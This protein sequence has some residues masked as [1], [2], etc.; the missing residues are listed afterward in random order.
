MPATD[1]V[2]KAIDQITEIEAKIAPMQDKATRLK[3]FVNT[4]DELNGRPPR[5]EIGAL[6][7]LSAPAGPPQVKVWQPGDFYNRPLATAVRTI[8][9]ARFAVAGQKPSPATVDEIHDALTQGTFRF[10]TNTVDGRQKQREFREV[11]KQRFVRLGRVVRGPP[12]YY[13]P[14]K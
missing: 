9:E 7:G 6:P 10:E 11:T 2:Q 4:S 1:D 8:L 5:Y 14:P 12:Q 3:I 13:A